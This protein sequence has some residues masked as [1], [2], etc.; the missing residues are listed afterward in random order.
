[1]SLAQ[2]LAS[3]ACSWISYITT[4]LIPYNSTII[5]MLLKM[6]PFAPIPIHSKP[7]WLLTTRPILIIGVATML[8]LRVN[9]VNS[10]GVMA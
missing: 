1:M 10:T 4:I 5:V 7:F 9:P 6:T 2:I 3:P 8:L